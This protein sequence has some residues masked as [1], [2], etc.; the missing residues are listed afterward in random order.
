MH[1]KILVVEDNNDS[2]EMMNVLIT[3]MGYQA[4][5]AKNS[6]E[7][8]AL[9]ESES[10][11]LILMDMQLPDID[12]VETTAMLK[13]NSKTSRIPVVACTAL[14]SAMLEKKASKVGISTFLIKTSRPSDTTGNHRRIYLSGPSARSPT[15]R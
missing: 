8:I 10:P 5:A 1:K 13:Q 14:M 7:A 6:Y 12:G 2:R 15:T 11:Q 4:I 9:A 3:K